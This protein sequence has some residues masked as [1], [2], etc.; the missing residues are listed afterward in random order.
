[1]RTIIVLA[2]LVALVFSVTSSN[3]TIVL[4]P[5]KTNTVTFTAGGI[6][7]R[8]GKTGAIK[9]SNYTYSFQNY[10]SFLRADKNTLTGPVN[11]SCNGNWTVTV[12]YKSPSGVV[13]GSQNYTLTCQKLPE[14]TGGPLGYAVGII[15]GLVEVGRGLFFSPAGNFL[16]LLP[17][18]SS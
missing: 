14:S 16:V 5:G 15:S 9:N 12:E 18:I 3:N 11:T 6:N 10:P 8:T 7:S 2:T 1:M 4:Q 13:E 17:T